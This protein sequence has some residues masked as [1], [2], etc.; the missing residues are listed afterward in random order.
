M[1]ERDST[2]PTTSLGRTGVEVSRL[3]LGTMMFGN[4]GN[5][6][7]QESIRIIRHAIDSGI[8]FF[9]SADIYAYGESEEILGQAIAQH[10]RREDLVIAGRYL[11]A[12]GHVRNLRH[13]P[14]RA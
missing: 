4:W 13:R 10:G 8:N 7:H 3:C 1:S 9:D 2:Q 14:R 6:D 5:K 12:P 11:P